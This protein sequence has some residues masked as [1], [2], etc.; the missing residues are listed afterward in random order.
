MPEPI[1]LPLARPEG[2]LPVW[3]WQP[4]RSNGAGI[5]LV[6]EIFG[7]TDYVRNRAADLA[8]EGYTV[9]VPDLFF[10]HSDAPVPPQAEDLLDRGMAL[11]AATDWDGAVADLIATTERLH[12]HLHDT[13]EAHPRRP[14][15]QPSAPVGLLGLCY[16]GGLAYAAAARP[17]VPVDALVCYYGSALP[18]LLDTTVDLPSLHHFGTADTFIPMEQV[19]AIR[20][21]VCSV[22]APVQF[23]LYD[24]AGHAFDNPVTAFHHPRASAEAWPRT[25]AFLRAHL[26]A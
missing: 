12:A 17:G 1:G 22:A 2:M 11:A 24:G 26:G 20:D 4:D 7:V 13:P 15:G 23:D 9:D 14:W 18:A 5:V 6:H 16:G 10:R 19:R 21:H 3:R 8:R 25:L